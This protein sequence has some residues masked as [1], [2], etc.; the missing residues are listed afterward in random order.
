MTLHI[1]FER[2]Q[3]SGEQ[4]IHF[5]KLANFY[6]IFLLLLLLRTAFEEF[7]NH[8]K[9]TFPWFDYFEIWHI[10]KANLSSKFG[11]F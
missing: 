10:Y 2:N 5:Q 1:K 3:V 11:K 9:I 4:D 8:I 7:L 6:H